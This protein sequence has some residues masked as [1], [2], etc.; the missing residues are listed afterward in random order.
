MT[1]GNEKLRID[2]TKQTT[3]DKKVK[4]FQT[5]YMKSMGTSLDKLTI[6]LG[7]KG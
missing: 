6:Q 3:E 4:F 5:C 7:L 1:F 2:Q